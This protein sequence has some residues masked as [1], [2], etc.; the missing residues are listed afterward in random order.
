MS[1]EE[2]QHRAEQAAAGLVGFMQRLT[3]AEINAI[4]SRT[5]LEIG[6]LLH[7]CPL[8]AKQADE[9]ASHQLDSTH[10]SQRMVLRSSKSDP[11]PGF[12]LPITR[13]EFG[14]GLRLKSNFL[15]ITLAGPRP[16]KRGEAHAPL[17]IDSF[18]AAK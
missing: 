5:S 15:S 6:C 3:V 17:G 4:A 13:A 7:R 16:A 11:E 18:C 1:A 9:N 14:K 10:L 12:T 8:S 2:N